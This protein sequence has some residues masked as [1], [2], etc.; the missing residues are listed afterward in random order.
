[1]QMLSGL[2]VLAVEQYGAGPFGTQ[3]LADLGAEVI[4]IENVADGG[5][6]S[7]SVGPHFAPGVAAD[8]ASV[9]FQSFNRNKKSLCVDLARTEGRAIL[10]DLAR[11]ADALLDNLRGDVPARLGL[12]HASL[13]DVNPR[14]VCAHLTGYGREGSRA[15]WPGYDYLMQAEAGYFALTGD[16]DGEPARMGLSIVDMMAGTMTALALLAGVLDARRSGTG[17]DVDLSLYDAAMYH[18][19]YVGNWHTAAGANTKREAR[20]AH[21]SLTPCQ[22]Y[23]TRDGWIY[24]MCNKEKFWRRL[25]G[26]LGRE[27]WLADP[28]FADFP[29]RL[30]HRALLTQLIDQALAP[31]TTAEWMARFAGRVPAAPILDVAQAMGNPFARERGLVREAR[32]DDGESFGLLANPIR[33]AGTPDVDRAAPG[34]GQHTRQ[35][36]AALGY[37]RAAIDALIA[38]G[39][40]R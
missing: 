30:C 9:F 5:D 10:R 6:V 38:D 19:S 20:S 24:L 13:K 15:Q 36:L 35:L 26:F 2:R 39:V 22:T 31:R 3:T 4:K 16:P 21:P 14:I 27:P 28:R 17:R 33:A 12:D 7:R 8:R 18:L 40:I 32:G 34:L 25:C 23:A 29:A 1:M 11:S 37:G